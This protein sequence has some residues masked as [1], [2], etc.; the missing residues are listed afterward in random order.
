MGVYRWK[1]S[2]RFSADAQ[3]IGDELESIEK[4]DPEHIVEFAEDDST[5]L[6]KCFT[7]NDA[8]AAHLYRLR[9]ARKIVQSVIIVDESEEREPIEYRAFESVVIDDRRQYIPTKTALSNEDTRK[10]IFADIGAS[11]K[12]ARNKVKTYKYL[13]ENELDTAQNHLDLAHEAV[14]EAR[15]REPV[16]V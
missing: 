15:E 9:E 6:H 12:E 10:Q 11:I 7:W 1:E 16:E 3:R 4:R 8:K 14:E 2:A 13:A 5:E